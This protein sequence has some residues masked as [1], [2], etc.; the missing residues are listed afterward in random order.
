MPIVD[1]PELGRVEFPEGTS[2]EVMTMAIK[3]ALRP[4]NLQ[5]LVSEKSA[6]ERA[7]IGM[8][9]AFNTLGRGATEKG[10][11]FLQHVGDVTPEQLAAFR[12]ET[13]MQREL[14]EPVL[15]TP[16]G[17]AGNL[18]GNVAAI[19]PTAMI[20][21]A[22]TI[23]GSAAIGGLSGA[24]MPTVGDESSAVNAALG[25]SLGG[26]GGA[27]GQGIGR[28]N[29]PVR[30]RLSP[31]AQALAQRAQQAG[32]PLDAAD[33]TG[34]RPLQ[35]MRSTLE[36][37]PL[38]G[39]RA[40]ADKAAKAAAFNRAVGETFGAPADA[41]TPA[42]MA[43]AKA[44]LSQ[45]FEDVATRNL[46]SPDQTFVR[47][48][49][50]LTNKAR[51]E[52]TPDMARILNNK[53]D[54][55]LAL[56][57]SQTG[58]IPGK[59]YRRMDTELGKLMKGG[60]DKA[61]L[62]GQLRGVLRDAMDRSISPDDRAAWR[63]LR[64]QWANMKTVEPLVA[65]NAEGNVS[66]RELLNKVATRDKSTAYLGGGDLGELGRIG[67]LFVAEPIPDSGTAQRSMWQR[68]LMGGMPDVAA[69]SLVG[70]GAL[71]LTGDPT[72]AIAAG[73]GGAVGIPLAARAALRN[74][75][76][77]SEGL[78]SEDAMLRHPY[79]MDALRTLPAALPAGLLGTFN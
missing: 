55:V 11:Q 59:A 72:A 60:G 33:L 4:N 57:D 47:Q 70:A 67:K 50:D 73:L 31:E 35:A 49:A 26:I 61:E 44:T 2:V 14:A 3:A 27:I 52:Y 19:A 17:F 34:S 58:Q 8:G 66:P 54:D 10:M 21:G 43:P 79:V 13:G 6:L 69:G 76:W 16:V 28:L 20:P 77:L 75:R 36:N 64:R 74:P 25:A 23:A 65:K 40:Q 9:E 38:V 24:L 42:V 41:L 51:R 39:A 15:S 63:M 5:R 46:L 1:V 62:I 45:G 78:L 53:V 29:S 12:Q 32:I 7:A 71:G 68:M 18:V 48:I 22:N 56:I 30:A 37:M